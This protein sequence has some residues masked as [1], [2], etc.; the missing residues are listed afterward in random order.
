M[1]ALYTGI[2]TVHGGREGHVKSSDGIL[3]IDL[4]MP[5]EMGGPGGP[6]TNP[7]QLFAGGYAAC[8]ESALRLVARTK[9]VPLQDASITARVTLNLAEAAKY[10]LSVELHGKI[11]GLTK[12]EAMSLMQAAHQVCPYSNAT[13]GNVDVQLFVD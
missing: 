2:A 8:F 4:R 7:E 1:K 3:D 5:K 9:K 10:V 11:D 12:D 6:G 13:R